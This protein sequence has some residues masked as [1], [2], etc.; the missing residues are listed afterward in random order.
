MMS[1]CRIGLAIAWGLVLGSGCADDEPPP[2][3]AAKRYVEAVRAGDVEEV[4][5]L[6]QKSA[7]EHLTA[8]AARASD[9]V[10]GRRSIEPVEMLQIVDADPRFELAEA[11]VVA[12]GSG[13]ATVRLV[14]ADES[15]RELDL[16]EEDGQW[17]VR[18]PLPTGPES[19]AP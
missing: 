14:G 5:T 3:R 2:V 13:A 12:E 19:E 7:M 17:R 16:V 10:G 6:V 15:V 8:A 18:I 4:L 11:T 9:Q 1:R